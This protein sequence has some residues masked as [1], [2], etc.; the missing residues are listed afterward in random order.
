MQFIYEKGS[1]AYLD[2]LFSADSFG[3]FLTM[4]KY[5]EKVTAYDRESL[6]A[7]KELKEKIAKEEEELKDDQ[8][9]LEVL[10]EQAKEKRKMW[11][12]L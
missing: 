12:L 1:T 6:K 11:K 3:E 5:V 8:A 10:L 7:Y 9:G 4:Y 2:M